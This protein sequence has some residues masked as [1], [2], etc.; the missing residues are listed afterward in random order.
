MEDNLDGRQSWLKMTSMEDDLNLDNL[1]LSWSQYSNLTSI[2]DDLKGRQPLWK[3]TSMEDVFNGRQPQ[4]KT[5]FMKTTQ[6]K[7]ILME[8][9][10]NER[11][12]QWKTT[13]M[14]ENL[15]GWRPQW[16][17]TSMEDDL[18]EDDLN[19]RRP[20]WKMISMEDDLNGRRPQWKMTS[21][22][23]YLNKRWTQWKTTSNVEGAGSVTL[24]A[25]EE[26][27]KVISY[28][29]DL[30]PAVVSMKEFC[31]V[32]TVSALFEE[33]SGCRLHRHLTSPNGMFLP[34]GW[35]RRKFASILSIPDPLR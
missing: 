6:W 15:N 7:N 33:A 4:W 8:D 25:L 27:Y 19:G 9:N 3:T 14:E 21:I 26:R 34:L 16:K 18:N 10:L 13:S 11:Q 12:P 35:W 5:T 30:K 29:D 31:L 17:T 32:N 20:Q 23:D 2:E 24:P 22:K 1:N 28:A